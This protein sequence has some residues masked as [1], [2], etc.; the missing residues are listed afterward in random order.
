[1]LHGQAYKDLCPKQILLKLATTPEL[2][3]SV[4]NLANLAAVVLSIPVSTAECESGFSAAK[5]IKTCLRNRMN[6]NTLNNLMILSLEGPDPIDFDFE[7]C[8]DIWASKKKRIID[9]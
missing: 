1:M 4:P 7:K 3:K 2:Q 5:Q 9:I 6:R 8:A